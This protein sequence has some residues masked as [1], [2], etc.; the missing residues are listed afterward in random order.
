VFQVEVERQ[1]N[2][3][4]EVLTRCCENDEDATCTPFSAKGFEKTRDALSNLV[5]A[6][7]RNGEV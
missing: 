6:K 2:V 7:N 4:R 5:G 3:S 1:K